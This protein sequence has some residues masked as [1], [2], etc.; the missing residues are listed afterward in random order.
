MALRR[1]VVKAGEVR[2]TA[3]LMA[4]IGKRA[5]TLHAKYGAE[6]IDDDADLAPGRYSIF[7]PEPPGSSATG[8]EPSKE[9]DAPEE[10]PRVPEERARGPPLAEE[11]EE[12]AGRSEGSHGGS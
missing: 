8:T 6:P 10:R 4:N 5:A 1:D 2:G 9:L 11:L 3:L 12:R 7:F